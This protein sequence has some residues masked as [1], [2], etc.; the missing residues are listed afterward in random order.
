MA[1]IEIMLIKKTSLWLRSMM[2]SLTTGLEYALKYLGPT[3][4]SSHRR[5]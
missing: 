5:A 2:L 1:T 4:N 3:L